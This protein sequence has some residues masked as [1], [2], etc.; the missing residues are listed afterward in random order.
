MEKRMKETLGHKLVRR[1]P[2]PRRLFAQ[3]ARKLVGSRH[4]VIVGSAHKVGSTWLYRMLPDLCDYSEFS[5]PRAV[6]AGH[7]GQA[8]VDIDLQDYLLQIHVPAGGHV[9]KTH[10][11]PPDEIASELPEWMKFVTVIRDPRDV[12]VSSCF[13]LARL[14]ESQ[15]GWGKRFRNLD[16][17]GRI[18]RIIEKGDFLVNRLRSWSRCPYAHKVRYENLLSDPME[19]MRAMLA[20]LGVHRSDT[21]IAKVLDKHSFKR[22]SG[23]EPG[24]ENREAFLRKGISGDWRSHFDDEIVTTFKHSRNGYWNDLLLELGYEESRDW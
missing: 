16:E 2:P 19:E 15:G 8:P 10:S 18:L 21:R 24:S 11:W 6:T 23:R 22:Q 9:F 4:F 3:A 17:R 12:I 14:P 13:Y 5:L 20:F 1:I 7:P